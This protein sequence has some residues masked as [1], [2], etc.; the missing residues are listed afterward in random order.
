[1]NPTVDPKQ[2]S[3][4]GIA[5]GEFEEGQISGFVRCLDREGECK[6]GFWK[7]DT[8]S[9]QWE[10]PVS[11]PWGKFSHYNKDGSFR[12]PCGIYNGNDKA[13]NH[14]AAAKPVFDFVTN[15]EPPAYKSK[16]KNSSLTRRGASERK[17]RTS[18]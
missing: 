13:W 12:S 10:I 14:I 18:D 9:D 17:N 8:S 11:R 5:E 1:L 15:E 3:V 7:R 6:V 16:D 2:N 4:I